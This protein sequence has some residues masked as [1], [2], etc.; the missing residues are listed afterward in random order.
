MTEIILH[1][2]PQSPVAEKVRVVLGMKSLDWHFVEIPRIPPKPDLMPLTGG[3]R[4]TPVMQ[5]GADI[6]CDSQ[7]I[8]NELEHRFPQPTL[9]PDNSYGLAWGISRW[10]DGPLFTHAVT[11]VLGAADELPAEFAADRGRLYFGPEFELS[12]LQAEVQHSITQLQGQYAWF[13]QQLSGGQ[14]FMLGNSPGLVDALGYYLTWFIRGR[15]NNGPDFLSQFSHLVQWESRIAD[16]GH[17]KPSELSS[18]EALEIARNAMPEKPINVDMSGLGDS[19]GV[20][21]VGDGGDPVVTGKLFGLSNNRIS[22]S[23]IDD[24]VGEVA[25][26]FPRVG[27]ELSRT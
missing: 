17:G 16:M 4:R 25:V 13:E 14:K 8:I 12:A 23:R 10:T 26:H 5:I 15:W 27:Y 2:Y 6:Y 22:I 9:F 11:I 18:V 7:C 20:A 1:N 21:P 24:Q 3:Y 19:V